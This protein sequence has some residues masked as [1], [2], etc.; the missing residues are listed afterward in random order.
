MVLHTVGRCLLRYSLVYAGLTV[1]VVAI[2]FGSE[3]AVFSLFGVGLL[4]V[5]FAVGASDYRV[6]GSSVPE[7]GLAR[8][9]RTIVSEHTAMPLDKVLLFYGVGLAVIAFATVAVAGAY[10]G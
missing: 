7:A 1:A 3:L 9:Q 8:G 5:L 2:V 4:L 10:L 6:V